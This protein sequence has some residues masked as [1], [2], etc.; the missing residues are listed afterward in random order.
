MKRPVKSF[1]TKLQGTGFPITA[2]LFL[3]RRTTVDEAMKQAGQLAG[4]VDAIQVADNPYSWA[5]I[6]PLALASLL[7]R[8][9]IDPVPRLACRDRNRIALQS[10]LLGLRAMGVS[11]VVLVKGSLLPEGNDLKAKP[12]F[13]LGCPELVALA[14]ALN[15]EG[16]RD[17][18]HEFVIGTG[19][20]VFGPEPGWNADYLLARAMAGARFLQTQPCFNL[21]LLR[22]YLQGLVRARVT[23]KYSV[24]VTLAPL[25]SA[26]MARWLAENSRGVLIPDELIERLEN[27][28]DPEQEGI[29]ICAELMREIAGVPGVSGINLLTLGNPRAVTASIKASGLRPTLD[30]EEFYELR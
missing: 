26:R 4:C 2:E 28:K 3:A 23:W 29:E 1:R 21:V 8:E 25:P 22:R 13:D 12:V 11:S 16:R 9:G 15:E 27:S 14:Q 20:T 30:K 5:Q 24:I 19:A 7:I 17:A 18:G 10:D 6:S